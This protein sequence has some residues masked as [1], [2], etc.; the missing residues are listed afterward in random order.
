MKLIGWLDCDIADCK[1]DDKA[2]EWKDKELGHTD[3]KVIMVESLENLRKKG[4]NV[5]LVKSFVDIYSDDNRTW[6]Y[7][8]YTVEIPD[9]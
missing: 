1:T 8:K 9:N 3:A 6:C 2:I 5:K 7:E 4:F